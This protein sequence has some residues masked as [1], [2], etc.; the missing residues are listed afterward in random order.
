MDKTKKRKLNED[1]QMDQE[2]EDEAGKKRKIDNSVQGFLDV[3]TVSWSILLAAYFLSLHKAGAP[4]ENGAE[5]R[6]CMEFSS[7]VEMLNVLSQEFD[8]MVPLE[9]GS[10]YLGSQAPGSLIKLRQNSM[11]E[12]LSDGQQ[13][14]SDPLTW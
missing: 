11:I 10:T 1:A 3:G 5:T 7:I 14:N 8:G 2:L 13:Q 6:F 12:V 4:A 9:T